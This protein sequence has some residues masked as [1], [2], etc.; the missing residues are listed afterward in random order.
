M[1]EFEIRE[2]NHPDELKDVIKLQEI[3][4]GLPSADTMSPITLTA[5]TIDR[6]R[7]GW[8]LGAFHDQ[9]MISFIISLAT[10]EPDAAYGHM[11]GVRREYQNSS[12]GFQ[13]LQRNFDLFRKEGISRCYTTFEPLESRNAHIYLNR[14][15]G[16]GVAYKKAHYY[17]DSGIHQGMPQDRLL[18]ELDV[19]YNPAQDRKLTSL[20]NVLD[21]YPIVS[22]ERMPEVQAVLLEIPGDLRR[23]QEEDPASALAYCMRTRTVFEEYLDN[24]GMVAEAFLSDVMNE[25]RRSFYLLCKHGFSY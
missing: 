16:H 6:P 9:K 25:K 24:R 20:A 3:V 1:V 18:V 23:F 17:I 22:P 12:V 5:L 2:L 19:E 11:L 15:G 4:G 13:M 14:L 10:A 21:R 7:V 8:V